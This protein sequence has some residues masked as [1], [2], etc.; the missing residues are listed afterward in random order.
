M[1]LDP[2]VKKYNDQIIK[3]VCESVKIPS[4]CSDPLLGMPYGENV[5]KALDHA[6]A[7][8][9]SLG[10]STV[11]AD[12]LYGYAEYGDGAETVAAMGHLDIVPPGEG[13]DFPPYAGEVLDG[14]ILGRGTQDDKG[15]LFSTLYALKAVADSGEKISKKVRIIFGT[16]EESGKMRDVNA[17]IEREG[18][19][20]MSFTPDG[21]YPV[22]NAEKGSIRFNITR[23]FIDN[24]T[25]GVISISELGGGDGL[26]VPAKAYAVITGSEDSLAEAEK[27][28]CAFT[29]AHGWKMT[30]EITEGSLKLT[31]A[32]KAAHA[33]LPGL[34]INA[35][36]R[37]FVS[38]KNLHSF[39]SIGTRGNYIS[40]I[41]DKI[42]TETDGFSMGIKAEH[43]HTGNLT[44]NMA[45][46]TGSKDSMML[47]IGIYVPAETIPFYDVIAK[48]TTTF[49]SNGASLEIVRRV[50]PLFVEETHPLICALKRGYENATNKDPYLISM[51]GSTY[52]KRMPN[53]VPFGATF[54]DEPDHA[55]AAN[56]KVLIANL[57][58][59]MRIMAYAILEMA[60]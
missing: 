9:K 36:G 52:S 51:C 47:N 4:L 39:I 6:L 50:A 33:T 24:C 57:H 19:P 34:G 42:G 28:V 55:H 45:K 32:G 60:K 10:F 16:D 30:S 5:A 54:K 2:F 17:Y 58:E 53:M 18:A 23:S 41:A 35:I 13:W 27:I 43:P 31:F 14:H 29:T 48:I 25:E 1:R 11:N 8:A 37:M 26:S 38:L 15:P 22:V 56:E 40:F 44:L 20:L 21:E 46:L 3:S 59:S 7:V 49:E 12:G